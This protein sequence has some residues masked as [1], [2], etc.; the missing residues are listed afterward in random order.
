MAKLSNVFINCFKRNMMGILQISIR[1]SYM[2]K[3]INHMG[4]GAI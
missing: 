1:L 2:L 4:E 3:V